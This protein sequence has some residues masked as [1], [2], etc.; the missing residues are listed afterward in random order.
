MNHLII[1]TEK[2]QL[3]VVG[4]IHTDPERPALLAMGGIWAPNDNL[5]ELVDWFPDATVLVAPLPGMGGSVTRN[6]HIPTFTQSV[7]AAIATLL[8]G[9]RVV[10]LGTSTGCLVTAGV[11][12]P[13]V[14]RHVLVEPFFRTEPLWPFT[15]I[16]RKMLAAEPDRKGAYIAAWNIFGVDLERSV[17]R[18]YRGLLEG[19]TAPVDVLVGEAALEP[20]R[21]RGTAP[22]LTS[23]ED[24]ALL[25][26][27]PRATIHVGP[28]DSGHLVAVE[29]VGKAQF[30]KILDDAL[31]A[32]AQA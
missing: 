24:R 12:S 14:V 18:D 31:A 16:A 10:L 29:G 6:F 20:E 13:Q 5:H 9:R 26:A 25:A 4:R 23:A 21:E 17:D 1:S 22:S 11:R 8:P 30:R 28:P 7:E 32:A 19:L 15:R 3:Y 27:L 2:D